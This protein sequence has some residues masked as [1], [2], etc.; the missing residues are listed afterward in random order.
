MTL[1]RVVDIETTGMAPPMAEVIELGWQDVLDGQLHGPPRSSLFSPER[2]S[3]PEVLAVHHILP[4]Q[5][6]G[7]SRFV[8]IQADVTMTL[9]G[10][11]QPVTAYVAHNAEFERQFLAD[12][13]APDYQEPTPGWICTYRG[14]LR[15]WPDA[16]SHGNQALMYWLGLHEE[17]EEAARHPPHRA[18]PDAHVTAAI[19]CRLLREA[20]LEDLIRWTDEPR[21]L[22]RC[23]IGKFRGRPW[24]EVEGGF[25]SWML[26]QPDMEEDYRW[27]A[28]R[29]LDRRRGA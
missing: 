17:L 6:E 22:P 27:N 8:P 16:P 4:A 28:R 29:E 11:H 7:R 13:T 2:P 26:R 15:V 25:L 24:S 20:S 5:L 14:A 18:G 1:L 21:L 19:L 23:P 12:W 3:P 10:P 9:M